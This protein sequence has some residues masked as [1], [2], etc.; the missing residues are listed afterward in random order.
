[1]LV[2]EALQG[3]KARAVMRRARRD[4]IA[5]V[6]LA[7]GLALFVF[8]GSRS[9]PLIAHLFG[10]GAV[11]DTHDRLLLVCLLL[12]LALILFGWRRYRDLAAATIECDEAQAHASLLARK[13]DLTGF[14][15]RR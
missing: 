1:M 11:L 13:D 4:L 14:L 9:A 15:N 3:G 7:C 12:N 8:S 6:V 2:G 10:T 5:G